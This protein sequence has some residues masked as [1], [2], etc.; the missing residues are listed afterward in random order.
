M[1][2]G[3]DLKPT[4]IEKMNIGN[5]A[6]AAAAVGAAVLLAT[7]GGAEDRSAMEAIVESVRLDHVPDRR[8]D[9]FEITVTG[10]GETP[11]VNGVTSVANAKTDLLRKI[12]EIAP[13]AIDSVIVLPDAAT[14]DKTFGVVNVSV[15]DARMRPSYAAE[16]GTQLLLGAP[17]E[18]IQH[19]GWWRIRSAEGYVAWMAASSF[20]RMTREEFNAWTAAP[21]IV[22][23]RLWSK[24]M[25]AA[26]SPWALALPPPNGK[27]F[28]WSGPG[29]PGKW[30]KCAT[31]N[32]P[33]GAVCP[34]SRS[35]PAWLDKLGKISAKGF[36]KPCN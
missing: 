4:K 21:K 17:M 36:F 18:V 27:D 14:G 6:K 33:A 5:C 29:W 7:C 3:N 34:G 30:L 35:L 2:N 31:R 26:N 8:D 12:R 32:S 19:D 23:A 15:A 16:M 13:A 20:V 9:V 25:I 1:R 22:L 11:V 10:E 24:A 28:G